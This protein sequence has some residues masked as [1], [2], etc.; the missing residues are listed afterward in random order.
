[1]F[2]VKVDSL[3]DIV[4]VDKEKMVVTVEPGITIGFLNRALVRMG[5]TLP[6]VPELDSLTIGGLVMGGWIESTSH[7]Y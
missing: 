2:K 4:N 7:N 3:Q 1:M 6:V 5:Y